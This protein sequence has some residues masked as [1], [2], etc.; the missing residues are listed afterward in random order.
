ME[1]PL[2]LVGNHVSYLDIPFLMLACSKVS[3]LAKSEVGRWPIIGD[4]ARAMDTIFVERDSGTQRAS[5]KAAVIRGLQQGRRIVLFPSGTTS[6]DESKV[7]RRGA[8]E[9]AQTQGVR[10]QPFRIRYLPLRRSAYIDR[11]IFPVH[12]FRLA[13]GGKVTATLEFHPP[14]WVE[15]IASS[16]QKWQ[17]WAQEGISA[18]LY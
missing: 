1:G 12:L 11:D 6:L 16:C 3:F 17:N 18:D 7:W 2:L 4:G 8:F 13:Q 14:Q 15:D 9:I 10:I 5:A